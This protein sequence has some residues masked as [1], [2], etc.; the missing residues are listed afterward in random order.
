MG[1]YFLVMNISED[2][3]ETHCTLF[4]WTQS[5]VELVYDMQNQMNW[6]HKT[7]AILPGVLERHLP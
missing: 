7:S 5:L 2:A 1:S 6:R 3:L 4:G